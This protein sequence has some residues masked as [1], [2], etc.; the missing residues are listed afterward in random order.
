MRI[1]GSSNAADAV[2][3][4]SGVNIQSGK[5]VFVRGLSDRYSLATL[6]GVAIPSLD[7]NKNSVQMDLIPSNIIDNILVF[8]TFTPVK[9]FFLTPHK[10]S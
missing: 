4:V 1:S 6:N 3:N 5:Y 2:K 10:T 9:S 8:K 7:P